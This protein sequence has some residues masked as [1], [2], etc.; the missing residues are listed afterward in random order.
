[1]TPGLSRLVFPGSSSATLHARN[2]IVVLNQARNAHHHCLPSG[3]HP[4]GCVPVIGAGDP[5]DPALCPLQKLLCLSPRP[6]NT[7]QGHKRRAHERDVANVAH[8]RL[9][10]LACSRGRRRSQKEAD[11]S[12]GK[13]LCHLLQG[14]REGCAWQSVILDYEQVRAIRNVTQAASVPLPRIRWLTRV[15][16][17]LNLER[18]EGGSEGG[19]ECGTGRM[20]LDAGTN[21]AAMW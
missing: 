9:T 13:T 17:D 5:L 16:H 14:Y 6:E 3:L 7:D 12:L 15:N 8:H 18:R 11:G 21:Q 20:G 19:M 4:P 10:R 1:M 2:E